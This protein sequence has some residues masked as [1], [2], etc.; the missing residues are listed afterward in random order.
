VKC[1]SCNRHHGRRFA[2]RGAWREYHVRIDAN[3]PWP[4]W[5]WDLRKD[6]VDAGPAR[7]R[8]R[9]AL[10]AGE[11]RRLALIESRAERLRINLADRELM[12]RSAARAA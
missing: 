10:T 2:W 11:R 9:H 12:R 1:A 5:W 6:M 8:S 3:E 4:P 7:R